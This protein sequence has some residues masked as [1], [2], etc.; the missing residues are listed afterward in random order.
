MWSDRGGLMMRARKN[1]RL[2]GY[3][4]SRGGACF[5]TICAAE[6]QCLFGTVRPAG[7]DAHIAPGVELTPDGEIVER[8][9]RST[10]GMEKLVI[11]PDHVHALI[12]IPGKPVEAAS[13][14]SG[15]MRAS[16]PT[17]AGIL[18]SCHPR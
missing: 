7:G 5:I 6:R 17:A 1:P 4:Y 16:A 11:M 12:T 18:R 13:G 9:L 10:P 15:P 3:D 8:D 2:H 14:S